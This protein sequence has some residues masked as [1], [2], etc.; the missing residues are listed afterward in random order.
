PPGS[1]ARPFLEWRGAS[2]EGRGITMRKMRRKAEG[3]KKKDEFR[4]MIDEWGSLKLKTV[5]LG[6]GKKRLLPRSRNL[7]K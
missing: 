1:K 6:S 4:I 3:G 5:S 2:D 7:F